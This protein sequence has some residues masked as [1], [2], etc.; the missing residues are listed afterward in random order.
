[1]QPALKEPLESR[2]ALAFRR[3]LFAICPTGAYCRED[4][5]Q[6]FFSYELIPTMRAPLEECEAAGAIRAAG[7]RAIVIDA[8]AEGIA[9]DLFLTRVKEA[10]PDLIIIVATFGT[11]EADLAW[12]ARFKSAFPEI[13]VGMRG[14]PCYTHDRD[15][16]ARTPELD[17]CLKGEYE[18]IF[19]AITKNGYHGAPGVTYRSASSVIPATS[20]PRIMDLDSLPL[21]DRSAVNGKLYKVRGLGVSQAT[22]R[23]QRGCPF[24]CSYCLVHTVSGNEARHRSPAHIASEMRS[25][26]EAGTS[27]F[28]L[29]ADTFTLD[30][31]WVLELCEA[32]V[33]E[34]PGAQWVTT[35][36]ADRVDD[37]LIR[38]MAR[39]GCYGL[40]FGLDVASKTIAQKVH[41]YAKPEV[42]QQAFRACDRA[43][44]IGLAYLMIGFL[45]ETEETLAETEQFIRFVRPDLLTVHFAHPYPGTQYYEDFL[46]AGA[47]VI[48][49]RAQAEP[50]LET[51]GVSAKDLERTA[52]RWLREHYLRPSVLYS[53]SRKGTRIFFRRLKYSCQDV[54]GF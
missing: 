24:P 34:C 54:R 26:M 10:S 20:I 11:L 40:S 16:L 45:W 19:D 28:Y 14:A 37:E 9:G 44:I 42:A 33:R 22:I 49:P 38:A 46:R 5:C 13:P 27:C 36:R 25:L 15:I 32:L 23:V 50:A 1:M 39:A 30:R 47:S 51:T 4:R 29:R 6:S 43:N 18:T 3:I 12:A 17:F 53:L 7:G 8:P 31:R 35:T 21:P 2:D 48:S 52:R 41:K